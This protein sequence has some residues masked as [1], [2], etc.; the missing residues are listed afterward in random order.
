MNT[1]LPILLITLL[2]LS[3]SARPAHADDALTITINSVTSPKNCT[4]SGW[5]LSY[6]RTVTFSGTPPLSSYIVQYVDDDLNLVHYWGSGYSAYVQDYMVSSGN[7]QIRGS[8]MVPLLSATYH[9][10]TIEYILSGDTILAELRASIQCQ[11]GTPIDHAVTVQSTSGN[12]SNLSKP[13]RNL[14][15]ALDDIP[16]YRDFSTLN[17]SVGTIKACQTFYIS[18]IGQRRASITVYARES[19]SN[20]AIILAGGIGPQPR[21]VDVPENYGQPSGYPILDQCIGK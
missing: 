5:M 2:L 18:N 8:Y 14:V 21:L 11:D 20:R 3:L 10:T 16:L 17:K 4:T 9:A 6:A 1:R 13:S 19:I 12:R 7:Q 15:L